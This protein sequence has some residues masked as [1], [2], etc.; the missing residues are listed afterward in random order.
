MNDRRITFV[1]SSLSIGGAERILSWLANQWAERGWNVTLLTLVGTEGTVFYML[2][3]SV[4]LR[5]LGVNNISRN[6]LQ[7]LLNNFKRIWKLRQAIIESRPETVI[8]FMHRTN[9]SVI[10]ALIGCNIP[11]IVSE[12]SI[13]QDLQGRIWHLLRRT[14]YPMAYCVVVLTERIKEE[15][16]FLRTVSVIPNPVNVIPKDDTVAPL[17]IPKPVVFAMGRLI[18]LKR[19]DMLIRAF[20]EARKTYSEWSLLILG[21]GSE[22][23][24][25]EAIIAELDLGETV[26]LPGRFANPE[27]ILRHGDLFV[28]S[29]RY[30]G[31]PNALC[32]AMACGLP[33]IATDCPTGPREIIRDGVDGLLVKNGDENALSVAM[34][35]LM[36]DNDLRRRMG[37]NAVDVTERFHPDRIM[38][39]WEKLIP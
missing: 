16:S 9:I 31:F 33:V 23:A 25:L 38:Q 21:E 15:L 6:P 2:N 37:H 18:E 20:F 34:Q 12:H 8:S 17:D 22:R 5:Q 36:G 32:E 24:H 29:S 30:E 26:K 3:P 35:R 28:L 10:L 11:V 27:R 19:F 13:P 4:Q 1:I 14:C 7:G 39:M